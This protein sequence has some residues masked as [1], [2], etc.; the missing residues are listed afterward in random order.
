MLLPRDA[1]GPLRPAAAPVGGVPE[2]A[3]LVFLGGF[4]AATAMIVVD[5]LAISKML[6]NDI[7]VPILL[8]YRSG[9][10]YR[11]SL[12]SMRL[13][14]IVVVFLGYVWAMMAGGRFLLVEMGLLSFVAVTQS[15]RRSSSGWPGRAATGAGPSPACRRGSACG[16]T[17]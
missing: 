17:R 8:R 7:V 5:S 13:S 1:G 11:A 4:S 6:T 10:I 16:S 15:R 3:V 9:D 2:L 14:I 12:H